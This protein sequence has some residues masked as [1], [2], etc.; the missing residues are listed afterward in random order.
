M[1]LAKQARLESETPSINEEMGVLLG[2][3][4]EQITASQIELIIMTQ[5]ESQEPSLLD[6]LLELQFCGTAEQSSIILDI[7]KMLI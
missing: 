6:V 5:P 2:I 4:H 3:I 1:Y 7:A